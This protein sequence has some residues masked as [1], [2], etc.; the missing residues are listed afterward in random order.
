M[1]NLY[2]SKQHLNKS[3]HW[4][5][6]SDSFVNKIFEVENI[7]FEEVAMQ[8]FAYQQQKN[9]VYKE[10]CDRLYINAGRVT[11]IP[12]IP[13]LPISFFKT[14]KII[15]GEEQYD[16]L[17][18]S[19]G[20][21]QSF[22]SR[23]YVKD[24]NLY[25]ESF[26]RCFDIFYGD[27]KEW[28]IIGLLPSYL[29]QQN[30]SLVTMVDELIQLS[31]H[32]KSGFY[33]YEYEKLYD[34]LQQSERQQQKTLL[35]GVTYALLD[36]A[37]HFP[38]R[39]SFTT[40]METG[41]MKGRRKEITRN[42]VHDILKKQF[43][44]QQV[45]S[46]YG[47]SELLSQAYSKGE[48]RFYCPPWMKIFVRDEDDP[49]VVKEMGKGALNIIDLANVYSCAFIATDDVGEVFEDSSF[50]VHGRLDGSDIR[51]CSLMVV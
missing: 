26:T 39:F 24:I 33:L 43:R 21:T 46:E 48:G 4:F 35:I 20:T 22:K 34:L 5:I 37:E 47:M 14:D 45:H 30:S 19:S 28:C 27:I 36:F 51:G 31:G 44:V 16:V 18:E 10:W 12:Q 9:K 1:G 32:G 6:V 15:C 13:F 11:A 3:K 38:M 50:T 29:Q 41:G 17:F 23:H 42:E 25:K 7:G 40:V 49:L 2:K 8:W